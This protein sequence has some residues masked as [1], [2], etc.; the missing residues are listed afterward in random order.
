MEAYEAH[1]DA[2]FRH[3]YYRVF[4][5]EKAKDLT[6]ECFVRTWERIAGGAEI[7]NVRA[8]LY[9]TAINLVIDESRRRKS[10]SLEAAQELGF[11]PVALGLS[12]S[13]TA[14]HRRIVAAIHRLEPSYR[15]VLLLRHIEGLGPKEI[16]EALDENENAVS[17]RLHRGLAKLKE[18]F[19]E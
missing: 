19:V 18:I 6:Q 3:I 4:D 8:F 2:I 10:E 16:A 7:G 15:E 17:V 11:E 13:E 1:S 12:A 5:R 14:E 9:R